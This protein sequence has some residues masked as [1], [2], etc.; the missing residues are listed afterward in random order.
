MF[1]KDCQMRSLHGKTFFFCKRVRW[2]VTQSLLAILFFLSVCVI[3]TDSFGTFCPI[4]TVCCCRVES[5]LKNYNR[6]QQQ[7][8][9]APFHSKDIGMG[10][11]RRPLD[12]MK[13]DM[14]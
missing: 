7:R 3:S 9:L 11:R 4:S 5:L 10:I 6:L 14:T 13:H 2:S 8:E 12:L 1:V